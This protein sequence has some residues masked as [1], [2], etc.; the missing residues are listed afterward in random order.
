MTGQDD[1]LT[2]R[3]F[4]ERVGIAGGAAA[5]YETMTTLGLI[6]VPEAWGGPLELPKD[7]GKGKTVLILGA[8][9]GGLTAA[10][11]LTKAGY[12]CEI[13]E[14]QNRAGGRSLT[15]RRGTVIE[16]IGDGKRAPTRQVC[17]FD[18]GL[19]LN[20]GPGRI[21]YHHE[22]VI[23]YAKTLDVALEVYV[24][25]T[26][27]NLFQ[28]DEAF[29]GKAQINRRVAND[30]R[31]YIA[32]LLAKAVNQG[33]LDDELSEG[34]KDKLKEKLLD[35]LKVFGSLNDDTS[36]TGSTRSGCAIEPLT[37]KYPCIA[38]E[39][40]S[41][42]QLLEST[43]WRDSFYQP[44]DY[45]WQPTLFQPVGGMDKLVEGF[46]RKIGSLIRYQSVVQR[47]E[48]QDDG[49]EVTYYDRILGSMVT[50]RADYCISNIPLPVLQGRDKIKANFSEDFEWAIQ[51]AVFADTCK[52]GWQANER[53]WETNN[54]IYGGISWI[55]NIITQ[56]WYPSNDY[57]SKNGTLTGAYNF[58][59]RARDLGDMS[60]SER[61]RVARKGAEKLHPEFA[62]RQI[63]PEEK[64]L[65]IAW[66]NVPFQLGGWA[67]WSS[68]NPKH[69]KAYQRL[70]KPDGA[71]G[72]FL[73]VGDQVSTL[74]GW[75][76]GAMMSAEH[77]VH[78]I[79]APKMQL[80]EAEVDSVRAPDTRSLV[81]GSFFN[82]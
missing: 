67:N 5:L 82:R 49:V 36:Y 50:K 73:I 66:Q 68:T 48:L 12:Q 64:G 70:L 7:I 38:P 77:V 80:L 26:T 42:E 60:L 6:N 22:R 46:I 1:V 55:D 21:P 3:H 62:N 13:I 51:Q 71:N 14:A 69:D 31:G 15:A 53:F 27:A 43:F 76:E 33:A 74:P 29:D 35:L 61:L 28:T 52:V 72:Q 58:T 57:F 2:R 63:V 10:Y 40:L 37:V 32:E 24:M 8:G 9:I 20:M 19:Y 56:M 59:D 23:H 17:Q 16:E 34:D 65:S 25:E 75:Q 11:E 78:L 79:A 30:T 44:I 18:E 4:L 39:P 54:Q 45:L 41:F 47:I 81:E